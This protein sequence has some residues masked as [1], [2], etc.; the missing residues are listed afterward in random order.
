MEVDG[1]QE[2]SENEG[3]VLVEDNREG[4]E[5]LSNKSETRKTESMKSSTAKVEN[6]SDQ[7]TEYL[8]EETQ[9]TA[10]E[11]EI[12]EEEY[13]TKYKNSPRSVKRCFLEFAFVLFGILFVFCL[14]ATII[15]I[16]HLLDRL[17]FFKQF[18][19]MTCFAK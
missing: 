4:D 6:A 7:G 9:A 19:S 1:N 18:N 16:L 10:S 15:G 3:P 12:V 2:Y 5:L 17:T 14:F 13:F 8:L 11:I